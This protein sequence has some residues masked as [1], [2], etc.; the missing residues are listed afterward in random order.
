MTVSLKEMAQAN[1]G[2]L[3]SNNRWRGR[4]ACGSAPRALK[5]V[6]RPRRSIGASGRPLNFTVRQRENLYANVTA[7]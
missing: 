5:D 3:P 6:A 7:R 4:D 2:R 1:G